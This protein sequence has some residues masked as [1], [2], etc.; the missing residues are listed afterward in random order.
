[1][2][3]FML[4]VLTDVDLGTE[5]GVESI[6]ESID[7]EQIMWIGL[8]SGGQAIIKLARARET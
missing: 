4:N 5:L 2:A 1:M 7:P 3:Q 8:G 6:Q